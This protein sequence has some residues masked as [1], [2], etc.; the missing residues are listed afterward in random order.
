MSKFAGSI[1]AL[2]YDQIL[3]SVWKE[4]GDH[5]QLKGGSYVGI[6]AQP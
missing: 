5:T 3:L 2:V 6:L 4:S 1:L